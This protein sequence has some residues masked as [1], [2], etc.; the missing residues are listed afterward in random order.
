MSAT[1]A[2]TSSSL[3]KK[4]SN[5]PSPISAQQPPQST[6]RSA[7]KVQPA[8]DT[9]HATQLSLL[10]NHSP[11]HV[12]G[13]NS[14]CLTEDKQHDKAFDPLQMPYEEVNNLRFIGSWIGPQEELQLRQYSSNVYH[15][16]IYHAPD[17]VYAEHH[18]SS[19][20]SE[21]PPYEHWL[22]ADV[23]DR[24]TSAVQVEQHLSVQESIRGQFY[25][26]PN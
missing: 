16:D 8:T 19:F 4:D 21:L 23:H 22:V 6:A 1:H 12:S 20:R 3:I 11:P 7:K 9:T 14:A 5:T 15:R 13:Q 10:S 24:G 17:L 26:T 2:A 18:T 25:S